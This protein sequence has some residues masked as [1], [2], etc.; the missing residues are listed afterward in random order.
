MG[1]L[2]SAQTALLDAIQKNEVAKVNEI[3]KV[4]TTTIVN[5]KLVSGKTNPLCRAAWLGHQDIVQI[6]LKYG[7]EI[8]TP[9]F[10]GKT[11]VMWSAIR[12]NMEMAVYLSEE[13]KADLQLRDNAGFNVFDICIYRLNYEMA[14]YFYTK[15]NMRPLSEEGSRAKYVKAC[16]TEFDYELFMG[17]LE[18][19]DTSTPNREKFFE[20]KRRE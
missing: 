19:G 4:H 17:M 1:N 14:F 16:G 11:A 5:C 20:R 6:L 15:F 12:H 7:A 13:C 18:N 3:V 2:L 9:S 8:D 10:D